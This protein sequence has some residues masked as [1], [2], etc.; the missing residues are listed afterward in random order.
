MKEFCHKDQSILNNA[1]DRKYFYRLPCKYN[2][3]L[4]YLP[5]Y[6]IHSW[7]KHSQPLT[8]EEILEAASRPIVVHYAGDQARPWFVENTSFLSSLYDFYK[9]K[10]C[11]SD[12]AKVSL[13]ATGKLKGFG[14]ANVFLTKLLYRYYQKPIGFPFYVASRIRVKLKARRRKKV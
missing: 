9:S 2:F 7:A 14:K 11:F 12:Q 5:R 1:L 6:L 8:E 3:T 10:T 13:F 4:H